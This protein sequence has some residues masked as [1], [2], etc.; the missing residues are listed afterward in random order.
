LEEYCP[1]KISCD[2]TCEK[3]YHEKGRRQ[4]LKENDLILFCTSCKRVYLCDIGL[5]RLGNEFQCPF[6]NTVIIE[7]EVDK[8]IIQM[9]GIP[10]EDQS[11][12]EEIHHRLVGDKKLKKKRGIFSRSSSKTGTLTAYHRSKISELNDIKGL[13]KELILETAKYMKIPNINELKKIETKKGLLDLFGRENVTVIDFLY[14]ILHTYEESIPATKIR[15]GV[16]I[17]SI[18]EKVKSISFTNNGELCDMIIRD[19]NEDEYW[20][21]CSDKYIDLKDIEGLTEKAS[22]ID[23]LNYPSIKNIF[24][25]AKKFSYV[26]KEM[27]KKYQSVPAGIEQTKPD[28]SVDITGSIPLILF[29]WIPNSNKF[30][31]TLLS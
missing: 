19:V 29:E 4:D 11:F 16:F 27:I 15:F 2:A 18:I 5:A 25:V 17:P 26:A 10:G 31:Q 8:S 9:K 28:G 13:T 7:E 1:L 3:C 20:V 22:K 24:F 30:K 21:F 6:D 23:Y 12:S 14:S